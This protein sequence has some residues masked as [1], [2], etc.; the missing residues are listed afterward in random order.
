MR[1]LALDDPQTLAIVVPVV[2]FAG[3]VRGFT[4]FGGPAVMI[5]AFIPFF[6]PVSVITKAL[7]IDLV[8]NVTLL[9]STHHEVDWK[10]MHTVCIFSFIGAPIGLY[11]LDGVDPQITKRIIAGVAGACTILMIIG[12]RFRTTP[13]AW[14]NAL[15]G[16]LA[17]ICLGATMIAFVIMI[18]FFASPVAAAISRANGVFWGFSMTLLL[19]FAHIGIGNI[20]F[21]DIWRSL[22]LGLLYLGGTE[23]GARAFR[24]VS[25]R[26]FRKG[27]MWMMLG[28][29]GAGLIL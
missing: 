9:R 19:I 28:L 23:L 12:L 22:L 26:N 5:L 24:K 18:Y 4:G 8:A 6:N 20:A 27:V 25:E 3:L 17:G 11:A 2:L 10:V 15:A 29:A 1:D 7:M 14:V 16:L 21:D 13:P